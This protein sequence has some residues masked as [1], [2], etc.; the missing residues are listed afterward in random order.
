MTNRKTYFELLDKLYDGRTTAAENQELNS[1]TG[2]RYE[3]YFNAYSDR[4]WDASPDE[5][6]RDRVD[7][8]RGDIM[9]RI[10]TMEGLSDR[11]SGRLRSVLLKVAAVA[12]LVVG[13]A[14]AGY[15]YAVVSQPGQQ[16]EV[17]TGFGQKS[18]V[19]LPD[20][21]RI[22]LNSGSRVSYSSR[23]NSR[24]RTV[25]LEGEAYFSVARNE[26]LPFVVHADGMA[27]TALG[28]KFNVKAYANEEEVVA[29]LVEGSIR[30]DAGDRSEVIAPGNQ[31][32]YNRS[33]GAVSVRQVGNMEHPMAWF[34]NKIVFS[35][36]TLDRIALTL[37]RMYNIKVVF[38][39]DACRRY[40]YKGLVHNNSL[41]N[42]LYLISSTSPV[43]YRISGNMVEFSSRVP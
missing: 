30:T 18:S 4:K 26:R 41:H 7:R 8:M 39:D 6:D 9:S 15:R 16:F 29:T 23:F 17:V 22:W 38:A 10:A 11:G 21:T 14:F 40:A 42:V 12:A 32:C 31:T 43:D 27:V 34:N 1:L 37:E 33:T 35:G 28:T 25:D 5:L 20:G 19:T 36:E 24:N 2:R 3:R 13:T